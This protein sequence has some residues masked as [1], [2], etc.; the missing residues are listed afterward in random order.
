MLSDGQ[1]FS[2]PPPARHSSVLLKI[3]SAGESHI[4]STQG[5]IVSDG[6]TSRFATRKAA[7]RIA[8]KAGQILNAMVP[9]T[10]YSEDVW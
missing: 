5:F 2:E 4:G 7:W 10:L 3:Q 6:T 1:V 8:K 9:G